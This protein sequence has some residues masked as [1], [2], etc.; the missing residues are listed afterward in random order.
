MVEKT[1]QAVSGIV[2]W[3]L[4]Y[5][6]E[7]LTVASHWIAC[8]VVEQKPWIRGFLKETVRENLILFPMC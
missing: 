1:C 5:L 3:H 7:L 4:L 2:Y 6:L 8:N